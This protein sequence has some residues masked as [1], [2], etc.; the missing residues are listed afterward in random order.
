MGHGTISKLGLIVKE[1][2]EGTKRPIIIDLRRSGG[3]TKSVLPAAET[4]GRPG[5]S[6]GPL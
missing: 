3:N 6:E 2:P 4:Q 1:K 5:L